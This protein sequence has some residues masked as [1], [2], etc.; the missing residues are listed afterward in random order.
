MTFHYRVH[1][2]QPL[3]PILSQMNSVHTFQ[4]YFPKIHL[5]PF[6]LRLGLPSGLFPSGFHTK[7]LYMF[8]ICPIRAICPPSHCPWLGHSNNIRWSGHVM[9]SFP[10]SYYFLP[11]MS[12]Y[13]PQRPV[14]KHRLLCLSLSTTD[15]VSHPYETSRKT[16]DLY[17]LI[18]KLLERILE[19]KRFWTEWKQAFPEFNLF[20]F[21]SWMVNAIFVPQT[22]LLCTFSK[23]LLAMSKLWFCPQFGGET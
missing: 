10:G 22:F 4:T 5:I 18:L 9:H 8:L 19:E 6:H 23:D 15:Q 3:V 21:S 1:K 13:Y 12:K 14:L 16:T 11:L 20:S 2:G 17:I 7:I